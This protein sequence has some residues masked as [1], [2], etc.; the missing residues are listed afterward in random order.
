MQQPFFS[1]LFTVST[2]APFDIPAPYNMDW[3]A[4]LNPYISSIAY[5]DRQLGRFFEMA[6]KQPWFSNTLFV[7][8]ADHSHDSPR[9]Q[10]FPSAAFYHI[11]LLFYGG[12]L[13]DEV[14]GKRDER[15][16]SQ[17]DIAS[18]LLHQLNLPDTAYRWSKNLANPYSNNFAFF[19]FDEGFGYTE[20]DKEVVW[21]K[22]SP[23]SG[24]NNGVTP[25][26]QDSLYRKGAAMLQVLMKDFLSK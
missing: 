4:S 23:K 17:T 7:I 18:T 22:K 24:F 3:A 21:N 15:R 6:K 12:A 20:G 1:A 13:K 5:T 2:H 14:R 16:G 25:Q 8:I 26:Q 9:N 11:P 10:R 19:T